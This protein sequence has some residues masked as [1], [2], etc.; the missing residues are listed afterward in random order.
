MS[1]AL[2]RAYE[3]FNA[4]FEDCIEH[5]LNPEKEFKSCIDKLIASLD[6]SDFGVLFILV[7]EFCFQ[8]NREQSQ[9]APVL[10]PGLVQ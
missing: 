5:D 6:P 10:D 8:R 4:V 7:S 2:T 3:E 1:E 9:E